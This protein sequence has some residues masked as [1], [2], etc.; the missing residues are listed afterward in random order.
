VASLELNRPKSKNAFALE[1]AEELVDAL[2]RLD[3]DSSVR[4]V[5]LSG[6]GPDFTSG[7]DIKS[8]MGV[9]AQLQEME[10]VAH[11]ARVL[12]KIVERFQAPFKAMH[13]FGKPIVCVQHGLSLGLAMELAAC[14]D[15]RYCSRD[16]RM[17]IREV[18][19]GI[20][21]DV[22]SLQLMPRLA[23]NQSLLNELIYTG[24]YITV[25]EALNELK[26]VSRVCDT[27]EQTIEAALELATTIASRSPVAVQG[28]KRNLKFSRDHMFEVGLDYNAIWNAAM[29]QGGDVVKAISAI[30]SKQDEVSYDDF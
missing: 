24:R 11:R 30:M 14:S 5:L 10:D 28:S 25:D 27:K 18:L 15:V 16:T 17:S 1:T 12:R 4:C 3:D 22:G 8:F 2:R 20:A 21:A 26:F 9:Y 29:M 19:I 13:S 6:K 23:A 7:V